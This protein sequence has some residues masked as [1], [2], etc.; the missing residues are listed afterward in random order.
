[1]SRFALYVCSVLYVLAAIGPG[2][3]LSMRFVFMNYAAANVALAWS[4][5]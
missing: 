1:V 3:S 2:V 4:V 5:S